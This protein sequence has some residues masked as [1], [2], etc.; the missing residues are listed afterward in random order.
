[1]NSASTPLLAP[2][3]RLRLRLLACALAAG[4]L[5][6]R[7]Q[8]AAE[9]AGA[10]AALKREMAV[11]ESGASNQARSV[12]VRE[13]QA[14]YAQNR[15]G[16]LDAGDADY[17]RNARLRCEALKG[18]DRLAC[19]TRMQGGGKVSGSVAE[20]GVYRELTTRTTGPVPAASAPVSPAPKP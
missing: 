9:P 14:A 11:C 3:G 1:V 18:D 12:C 2:A 19:D 17:Q 4:G 5:Y 20:G 7:G 16:G 15:R 6:R 13:A 8:Q 10:Q